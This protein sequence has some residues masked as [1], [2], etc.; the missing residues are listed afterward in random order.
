MISPVDHQSSPPWR[1]SH[2]FVAALPF[3]HRFATFFLWFQE[4]NL[5]VFIM[6]KLMSFP[7]FLWFF[8]ILHF[9]PE[10]FSVFP[11]IFHHFP[12]FFHGVSMVF[13]SL[14]VACGS[15]RRPRCCL[16]SALTA[17]ALQSCHWPVQRSPGDGRGKESLHIVIMHGSLNVP[18]EHH[19]TIRYMV[20]NGYY[21]VMFNIPKMGQLPTFVMVNKIVVKSIS[22]YLYQII[23]DNRG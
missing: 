4:R 16:I 5:Q 6:E 17:P 7:Y 14:N 1:K 13:P 20:Y 22:T 11:H 23:E 15:F 3:S 2:I 19:P 12:P 10:R 9:F 21:K 18:I 8:P